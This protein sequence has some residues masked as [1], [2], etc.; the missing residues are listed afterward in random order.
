MREA[1]LTLQ[2]DKFR[3]AYKAVQVLEH[4]PDEFEVRITTDISDV[5]SGCCRE[6]TYRI[7][8]FVDGR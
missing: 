3:N 7:E 4:L 5:A 6:V 2:F 8:V 1:L